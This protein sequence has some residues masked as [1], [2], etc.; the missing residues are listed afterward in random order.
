M[1]SAIEEGADRYTAAQT[2]G[3]LLIQKRWSAIQKVTKAALTESGYYSGGGGRLEVEFSSSSEPQEQCDRL[4]YA[5][6][7]LKQCADAKLPLRTE[8]GAPIP[9]EAVDNEVLSA[10]ADVLFVPAWHD[11]EFL[12]L[13]LAAIT[14]HQQ[15]SALSMIGPPSRHS[16]SLGCI[17]ALLKCGLL[18]LLPFALAV[19][20]AAAVRQEVGSAAFAFY[21]VG[22]GVL[23]AL[24]ALGVGAKKEGEWEQA[25][26]AW[27]AFRLELSGSLAGVGTL[28]HLRRM[29]DGGVKVPAVAFDLAGMLRRRMNLSPPS[30]R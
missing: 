23:A 19:G 17:G 29:A 14:A 25:Y 9:R 22:A 15:A 24:S 26:N 30:G 10:C 6:G 3:Q 18:L 1:D 21:V 2:E 20:I 8:K 12:R 4:E 13:G 7:I 11:P 5:L 28:E 16:A 27:L